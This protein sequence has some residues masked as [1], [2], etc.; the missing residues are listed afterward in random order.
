MA[1][2]SRKRARRG[3]ACVILV[4][5]SASTVAGFLALA[6]APAAAST[7][8]FFSQPW[9]GGPYWRSPYYRDPAPYR[10]LRD[11]DAPRRPRELRRKPPR[12]KAAK[13]TEQSKSVKGPLLAVVSIDDQRLVLY[14]DGAPIAQSAV[15]TGIPGHP[16]PTGIF[17]VIQKNRF[18]RSNIYSGAPMPFMQRITW[19]GIALHAG[20]VPGRPASHGCIR[21]PNEFATK[22]WGMT[23]L[24][25]RV[26][27]ARTQPTLAEFAHPGLFAWRPRLIETPSMDEPPPELQHPDRNPVMAALTSAD[28]DGAP[29]AGAGLARNKLAGAETMMTDGA[30]APAPSPVMATASL[31][32]SIE[33]SHARLRSGPISVFIS[34]K[35]RK[36]YVR[37]GFAPVF[38][39]AIA[40]DE[41]ERP[42]GTHLFTAMEFKPNDSRLRWTV[43]SIPSDSRAN[44]LELAL[45]GSFR[46]Q[47]VSEPVKSPR[48]KALS[49]GEPP[50][51]AAGSPQ[52]SD[53]LDRLRIPQHALDRISEMM[54]PGASFIVSDSGIGHETGKET[55]FIVLTR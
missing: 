54:S 38:D 22:L 28:G 35:D 55:D 41:P 14:A 16:T 43:V 12:L 33:A 23:R 34:R 49:S 26:V 17:S 46:P 44:A 10:I 32:S 25:A 48:N 47:L 40:I 27:I 24:G 45:K 4:T 1:S 15:S 18:H 7:W 37:K 53:A 21:L 30:A 52:P 8:G 31:A 9:G 6:P 29:R 20:I 11:W 5:L 51:A 50:R 39:V 42:I 13:Q 2:V 3:R 36:L 19:S